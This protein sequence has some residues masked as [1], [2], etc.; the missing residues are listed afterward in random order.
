MDNEWNAELILHIKQPR[1]YNFPSISRSFVRCSERVLVRH[2]LPSFRSALRWPKNKKAKSRRV[3]WV[4]FLPISH[5]C[6]WGEGTREES[7]LSLNTSLEI[8]E[9]ARHY[10]PIKARILA[11]QILT[12]RIS[13]L[14]WR[15]S[16]SQL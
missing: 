16:S 12:V 13:V 6:A 15:A 10:F 11:N 3:G 9:S 2:I 1:N 8:F 7:R 4:D 14:H 5:L